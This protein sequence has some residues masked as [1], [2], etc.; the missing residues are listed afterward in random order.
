ME[1]TKKLLLVDPKLY[2]PSMRDKTL[3][4]LDEEIDLTLNADYSA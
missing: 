2:R 4:K 3:S 1:N